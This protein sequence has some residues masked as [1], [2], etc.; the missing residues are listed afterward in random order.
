MEENDIDIECSLKDVAWAPDLLTYPGAQGKMTLSLINGRLAVC[1]PRSSG[2]KPLLVGFLPDNVAKKIRP[3]FDARGIYDVWITDTD[4]D[5]NTVRVQVDADAEYV[6]D[7]RKFLKR[8]EAIKGWREKKEAERAAKQ[9]EE[10][11]RARAERAMRRKEMAAQGAQLAKK[12]AA[13]S[14]KGACVGA[15]LM[16]AGLRKYWTWIVRKTND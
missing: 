6:E 1:M 14:F 13:A 10:D 16:I 2:Q 7:A 4:P 8:N 12:G 3:L 9:T 5:R 15:V 11:A